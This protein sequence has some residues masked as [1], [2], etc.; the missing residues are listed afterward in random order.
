MTVSALPQNMNGFLF[1]KSSL[2]G[3]VVILLSAGIGWLQFS[4]DTLQDRP[5]VQIENLAQLPNGQ[6]L[7]PASLG[8]QHFVADV[9]WLQLIQVLGKKR[10]TADEY[11]WIYHALDVITTLDPQYSYAYEVGGTVL[12]ELAH[13]VDLS[14]RILE[15]GHEANP[16]VWRLPFDLGYNYFFYLGDPGKAAD[17]IAQAARLPGRPAY[18]PGLATR[19]YAEAQNPDVALDFLAAMWAQTENT[20]VKS[21]LETRMKE[22]IIERDIRHLEAA[23]THYRDRNGV[24]PKHMRELVRA[25]EVSGIP[26]E[27]F[28]GEYILDAVSGH[29]HSSTHPKRLRV[30]RPEEAIKPPP[31][32]GWTK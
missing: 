28:G 9:L 2:V 4:L 32:Y 18:L 29:I 20:Y 8:Y 5:V 19:M 16:T 7:K 27:P 3:I 10:N 6:Y 21:E 14:N 15:K 25:G 12:T 1:L 23:V 24:F 30:I 26:E 22:L 11:E 31:Q 13:R 17:Y